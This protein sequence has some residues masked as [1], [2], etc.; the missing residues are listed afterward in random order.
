M[1]TF[2]QFLAES[3][4]PTRAQGKWEVTYDMYGANKEVPLSSMTK[5]IYASS[6]E[7]AVAIVKKLVGGRNHVAKLVD[8]KAK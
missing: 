8:S 6:G 3:S 4:D 2:K 1:K 5:I 7:E